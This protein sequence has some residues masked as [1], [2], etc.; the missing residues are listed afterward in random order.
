MAEEAC[1]AEEASVA[2]VTCEAGRGGGG[3][4]HPGFTSESAQPY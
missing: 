3:P 4:R 2:E 1:V